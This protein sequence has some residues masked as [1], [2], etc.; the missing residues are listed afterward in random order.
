MARA[1]ACCA[2]AL[3]TAAPPAAPPAPPPELLIMPT[4]SG[5][6]WYATGRRRSL[7]VSQ[8]CRREGAKLAGADTSAKQS[9][10]RG[11]T[12]ACK[13]GPLVPAGI[14]R[15]LPKAIQQSSPGCQSRGQRPPGSRCWPQAASAA[16]AAAPR[17][18]ARNSSRAVRS[19]ACF[20]HGRSRL[21][22]AHARRDP[23]HTDTSSQPRRSSTLTV[24]KQYSAVQYCAH[25]QDGQLVRPDAGQVADGAHSRLLARG[26]RRLQGS[27]QAAGSRSSEQAGRHCWDSA[28][29]CWSNWREAAKS[30]LLTHLPTQPP[31]QPCTHPASQPASQP[32]HPTHPPASLPPAAAPRPPP[33]SG[34]P[35]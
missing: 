29:R 26:A 15:R 2:P 10:G 21:V 16:A 11:N 20:K 31:T 32:S 18:P 8:T 4:S 1:A 7:R 22:V 24:P 34:T 6:A 33:P 12:S 14:N 9:R 13:G 19:R 17:R 5:T 3:L 30:S 23:S 28:C 35:G 25:L 27:K